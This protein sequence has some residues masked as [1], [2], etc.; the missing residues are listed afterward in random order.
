MKKTI[1]LLLALCCLFAVLTGC[2]SSKKTMEPRAFVDDVLTNANFTDS[3]SQ[4][5]D[6]VIPQYYGVDSADYKSALVY[7]GTA[8]TAE[9]I[10]C[11]EAVDAAA[12]QRL[13]HA[14]NV[15]CAVLSVGI[16]G[17]ATRIVRKKGAQ[18]PHTV[19]QSTALAAVFGKPQHAGAASARFFKN[20]V[21]VCAAAVVHNQRFHAAAVQLGECLQQLFVRLQS[22]DKYNFHEGGPIL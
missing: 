22:G 5:D 16:C 2:G 21:I 17:D 18:L 12:A 4:L 20:F 19:F 11:F 13:L 14:Q 1:S 10:V 7:C 9:Q 3:L 15:F 6:A 8:A